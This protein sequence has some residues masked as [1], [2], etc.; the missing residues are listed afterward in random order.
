MVELLIDYGADIEAMDRTGSTPLHLAAQEG[1]L[2]TARLLV[3]RGARTD[4]AQIDGV[5]PI[6]LA[7]HDS[8]Y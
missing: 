5:M 4:A 1:H 3:T 2:A 8:Y 6:H 7:A